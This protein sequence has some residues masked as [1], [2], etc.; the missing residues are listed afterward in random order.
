MNAKSIQT[1][2]FLS[3]LMLTTGCGNWKTGTTANP[4]ATSNVTTNTVNPTNHVNTN[5]IAPTNQVANQVATTTNTANSP[6]IPST[7]TSS[8]VASLKVGDVTSIDVLVNKQHPLPDGYKP[9]DLVVPDV[10]FLY[11]GNNENHMMRQE[12]A[13]ALKKLFDG[14]KK[15]GIYLDGVS[16][17]RSY[18]TQKWLFDSYVKSQG[19]EKAKQFSALPGQSEHQTGLAIDVSGST[20]QCAAED[21]FAATPEAK[22]LAAHAEEYGFIIRYPL[23]K[24]AITGY[25]YEPWHIRYLGVDV[26]MKIYSQHETY[27]E[28]LKNG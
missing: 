21:C 8:L 18:D 7:A 3:L 25:S 22:W 4:A 2:G 20:G 12:A 17:F 16:A 11:T 26:A 1:L 13:A 23:G 19:E 10:P 14:A 27:E 28:F 5:Q 24:E 15:D 6:S 9:S